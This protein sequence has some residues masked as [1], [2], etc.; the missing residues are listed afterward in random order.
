MR[1][2]LKRLKQKLNS[3]KENWGKMIKNFKKDFSKRK[4]NL[5]KWFKIM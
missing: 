2:K 5:K 4:E 3:I 1:K